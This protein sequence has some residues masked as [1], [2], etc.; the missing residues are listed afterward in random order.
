VDYLRAYMVLRA[1]VECA[2]ED[3]NCPLG[4]FEADVLL[5]VGGFTSLVGERRVKVPLLPATPQRW[6]YRSLGA[7]VDKLKPWL[8]TADQL[9]GR[10]RPRGLR[11]DVERV[12]RRRARWAWDHY[13]RR[14]TWASIAARDFPKAPDPSE[15]SRDVLQEAREALSVAL[16]SK[17][18]RALHEFAGMMRAA[19]QLPRG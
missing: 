15:R 11:K 5:H 17:S 19:Y 7:F 16:G 9:L 12:W 8:A 10:R 6:T 18:P 4:E 14:M 13:E 3:E 1:W 2:A